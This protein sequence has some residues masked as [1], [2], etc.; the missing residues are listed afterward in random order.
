MRVD[1]LGTSDSIITYDWKRDTF[2]WSVSSYKSVYQ[3]RVQLYFAMHKGQESNKINEINLGSYPLKEI[4][5]WSGSNYFTSSIS[6]MVAYAIYT[7]AKEINIFGVDMEEATEYAY[8]RPCLAYWVGFAQAKDVRVNIMTA[9]DERLFLYGYDTDRQ[10][11]LLEVLE[12]RRRTSELKALTTEGDT[13]QQWI[14]SMH[15][16]QTTINSIKG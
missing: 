1:I 4:M 8:Q 16:L 10:I 6:Y 12:N 13:K 9:L 7:G 2:K 11:A 5:E 15:A 14:G 3:D